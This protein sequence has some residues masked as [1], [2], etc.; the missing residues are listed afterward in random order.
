[1]VDMF[2]DNTFKFEYFKYHKF[3]FYFYFKKKSLHNRVKKYSKI[4]DKVEKALN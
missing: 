2:S 3:Q 1:M 4:L